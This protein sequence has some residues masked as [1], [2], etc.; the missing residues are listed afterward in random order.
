MQ[1][2]QSAE[3]NVG[4]CRTTGLRRCVGAGQQTVA[5]MQRNLWKRL[6]QTHADGVVRCVSGLEGALGQKSAALGGA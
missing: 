4:R 6:Q 5:G 1:G 3:G 2:R